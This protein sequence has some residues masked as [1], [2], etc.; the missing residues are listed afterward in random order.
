M[1]CLF[2]KI[3][4]H[5]IP[6]LSIREDAAMLSFLD[7]NPRAAGHTMV[8]P[9]RHVETLLKVP[10]EELGSLWRA[11]QATARQLQTALRP[12]GFTIGVN[13]GRC[14]GQ[15]IDHLHVH[16]IP[17]WAGDGGGSVHDVINAPPTEELAKIH[18]KIVQ[19]NPKS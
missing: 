4:R 6:A 19:S 2:C 15:A 18:E 3:A 14:A 7:I 10:S 17:R 13:Q 1:D 9:K 16:I 11:V 8:I 12:D 5:E